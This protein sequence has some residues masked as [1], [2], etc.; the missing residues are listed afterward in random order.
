M[1][2]AA[3]SWTVPFLGPDGAA[4][5][6]SRALI[7]INQPFS[8]DLLSK[9][10]SNVSW[11]ACADGG[12]NR[13]H[14]ILVAHKGDFGFYRPDLI[15]G[16][17]DSF[18][19][20]VRAVWSRLDV[21]IERDPSQDSTDVMKCISALPDHIT[22]V[23]IL[24]GFSGRLD[25]TIHILALLHRL[26]NDP[27]Q[28]KYFVITD[29]SLGWVLDAGAHEIH[30]PHPSLGASNST[31]AHDEH[32]GNS[33]GTTCGILPVGIDKTILNTEGLQWNLVN[34]VSSFD[35]MVS[36][37]NRY[38]APMVRITTSRPVWWTVEVCLERKTGGYARQPALGVHSTVSFSLDERA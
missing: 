14:D 36:T 10:W 23:V 25:H 29:D 26:R 20:D 6:E 38:V 17:L 3:T 8:Y 21:S 1:A 32:S 5:A 30:L 37:S 11:R 27:A 2:N 16:D 12:A 35:G 19:D 22:E 33:L 4:T 9:L 34:A 28:R 7:I 24:G 18:R 15:R 31:V 13:L